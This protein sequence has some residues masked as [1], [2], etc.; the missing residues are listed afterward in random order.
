M[1]FPFLAAVCAAIVCAQVPARAERIYAVDSKALLVAFDSARPATTLAM[2]VIRGLAPGESILGIDFRPANKKLYALGS[3]S[4][5]YVVDPATG[6]ATPIGGAP[7]SP[8][9]EWDQ[10]RL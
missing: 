8:G 9:S 7:F 6:A 4:R 2:S 1:K 3:T 10:V 5:V